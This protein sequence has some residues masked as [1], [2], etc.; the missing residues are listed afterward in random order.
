MLSDFRFRRGGVSTRLLGITILIAVLFVA[1]CTTK[2]GIAQFAVATTSASLPAGSISTGAVY[3]STTLT[4]SNG[5]APYTWTVTT[6]NLPPGLNLSTAGVISGT[7]TASGTFPFTVTA[8][9]SATPT[10][11]TATANL[12]IT[13]NAKLTITSA[14]TLT[15]VGAAGSAYSATVSATGGVGPFTWAVNTGNLP[16]GLNLTGTSGTGTIS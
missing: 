14:G 6:G 3:P 2:A 7:A 1:G 9:D 10:A 12:S 11:H 4:A 13:I 8:T 5:T 15:T 16:T